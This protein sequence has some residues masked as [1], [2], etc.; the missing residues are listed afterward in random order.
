[1][2]YRAVV[3]R[4]IHLRPMDRIQLVSRCL[5]D[6]LIKMMCFMVPDELAKRRF[7][8]LVEHFIQGCRR[9][10]ARGETVSVNL[11]KCAH[12]RIAMLLA[13]LAIHVAM[14]SI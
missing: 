10:M 1:M 6:L 14:T 9:W 2:I 7:A 13:D 5:R 11:A 8:E 12:E 4:Q 3:A